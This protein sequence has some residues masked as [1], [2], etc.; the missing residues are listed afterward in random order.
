[1]RSPLETHLR[2]DGRQTTWLVAMPLACL[3]LRVSETFQ[4]S[5]TSPC[6]KAQRAL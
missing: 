2:G 1:M 5:R 3:L 6:A 4:L